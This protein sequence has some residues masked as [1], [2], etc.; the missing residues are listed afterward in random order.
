MGLVVLQGSAE[1]FE[2]GC[3]ECVAQGIVPQFITAL[4]EDIRRYLVAGGDTH[5][6]RLEIECS[7]IIH[8]RPFFE[9]SGRSVNSIVRLA[10]MKT[11]LEH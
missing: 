3:E 11:C 7:C 1:D 10:T 6:C 2:D 8:R 5:V 4:S 9:A